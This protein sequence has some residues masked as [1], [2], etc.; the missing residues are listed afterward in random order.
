[1]S[2]QPC[3][4][5]TLFVLLTVV[6]DATDV[7]PEIYIINK[8][9]FASG[10]LQSARRWSGGMCLGTTSNQRRPFFSFWKSQDHGETAY[11]NYWARRGWVCVALSRTG[12]CQSRRHTRG[13]SEI[14]GYV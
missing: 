6:I 9:T 12:Y 10:K 7:I 14:G 4:E 3:R 8:L 11:S 13:R 2:T 5:H 1:V